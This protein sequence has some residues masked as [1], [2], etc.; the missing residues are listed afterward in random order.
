MAAPTNRFKTALRESDRALIGCWLSLADGPAAE[1]LG[2]CGFDWLVI[3][4]EHAPNDIPTIRDQ[5]IALETSPSAA[6]VRVPVGE[7]WLIKQ[8]LDIG[9]QSVMVPMV[10]SGEQAR[11]LVRACHYPPA[12]IRGVGATAARATRFASVPDYV[13]TAD[14]QISLHVQVESRAGLEA[15]D[16][17]LGVEGID[18]V[19]IG[20]ADL[21]SDMGFAGD[22]TQPEVHHAICD[23]LARIRAGGKAAGVLC[24]DE[25]VGAYIDAGASYVAAAIDVISMVR[26]ARATAQEWTSY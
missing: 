15:L 5:L 11:A 9:A 6:I 2:T 13:A 18:G 3:D 4:G 17:I 19:F 8:V 16:D 26:A 7:P 23:A 25:R 22:S 1:M 14:A 12:G 21:A 10:E 20:P 24:L